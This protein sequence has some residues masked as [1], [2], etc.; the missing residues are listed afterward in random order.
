MHKQKHQTVFFLSAPSA[1]GKDGLWK[2]ISKMKYDKKYN[3]YKPVSTTCRL[4][5]LDETCGK[6]YYYVYK[7]MIVDENNNP[8]PN[9]ISPLMFGSEH[10]REVWYCFTKEELTKSIRLK[11]SLVFIING[12][13]VAFYKDYFYKNFPWIKCITTCWTI[14]EQAQKVKFYRRDPSKTKEELDKIYES[15]IP[16]RKMYDELIE[17][18][19]F[20]YVDDASISL[21]KWKHKQYKKKYGKK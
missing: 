8:Q 2:Y 18:K 11:K 14:S 20:D 17:K 4:P 3:L 21:K 12:S 13:M 16:E 7:E 19:V 1:A 10:G 5:R 6:D 9:V 15:R